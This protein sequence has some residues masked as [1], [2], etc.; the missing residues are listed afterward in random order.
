VCARLQTLLAELAGDALPVL[1]VCHKGVIRA[2]LVL[3]TGWDMASKPPVR[4]GR[5]VG[6]V[7]RC[8]AD[9]RIELGAPV[10][11]WSAD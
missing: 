3:S 11:L 1:A 5:A 7:L 4:L 2:A 9:G 10:A 8:H 6:C